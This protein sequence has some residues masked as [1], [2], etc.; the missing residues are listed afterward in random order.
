MHSHHGGS[1][2]TGARVRFGTGNE[3]TTSERAVSGRKE[4]GGD[5]TVVFDHDRVVAVRYYD[6]QGRMVREVK[7]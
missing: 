4:C 1:G 6:K 5:T 7:A 2:L 3:G